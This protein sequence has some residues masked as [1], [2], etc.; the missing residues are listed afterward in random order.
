MSPRRSTKIDAMNHLMVGNEAEKYV[1]KLYTDFSDQE[2]PYHNLRHTILVLSNAIEIATFY[3]LGPDDM[4]IIKIAA[5][6]HDIGHLFGEM[7]DH[8]ENGVQI[9]KSY[10]GNG[11]LPEWMIQGISDCIL[12]TKL[13]SNPQTLN[14]MILCDADTYHLG[15]P[16]FRETNDAVRR[17]MEMR[18]GHKFPDWNKKAIGFLQM[19]RFFTS[20][21]NDLLD[22]GK[23]ANIA[24]LQNFARM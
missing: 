8:E 5:C 12:A 13:P 11:V 17:E 23:K 9:M 14:E 7:E 18:T 21:C 3:E 2:Y 10:F 4:L 1:L 22:T 6:F 20:Y 19:H 24:W 15:T 16:Y